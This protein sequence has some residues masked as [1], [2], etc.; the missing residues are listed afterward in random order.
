MNMCY[1]HVENGSLYEKDDQ[2]LAFSSKWI[3]NINMFIV[4]IC[5]KCHADFKNMFIINK[6]N[7]I[8][9]TILLSTFCEKILHTKDYNL[10]TSE[11]HACWY[12]SV[13]QVNRARDLV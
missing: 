12:E 5:S 1:F 3:V 13:N 8:E 6:E 4:L 10:S 9:Y 7:I 2:I 11:C